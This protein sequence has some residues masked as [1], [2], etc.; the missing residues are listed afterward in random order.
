MM[1]LAEL[2][3]RMGKLK[4]W[5]LESNTIV[6]DILF[7]DFKEALGYVN[8]VGELAEKQ[9]HHPDIMILYNNVRLSLTTHSEKGLTGKDFDLA[10]EIDKIDQTEKIEQNE[11]V[12]NN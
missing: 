11:N 4:D 3:K 12:N 2:E 8:K 7:K 9:G 5:A 1:T 10:E 6:K